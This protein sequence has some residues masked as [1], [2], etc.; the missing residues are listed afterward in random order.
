MLN[1]LDRPVVAGAAEIGIVAEDP[2]EIDGVIETVLLDHG[3]RLDEGDDGGVD[4]G[5]VEAV[6]GHVVERPV[7]HDSLLTDFTRAKTITCGQH[8][9]LQRGYS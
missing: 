8:W 9:A 6:P 2:A 1:L 7:F 5:R 4:L 3:G